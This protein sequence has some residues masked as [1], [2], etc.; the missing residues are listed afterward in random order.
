MMD[1]LEEHFKKLEKYITERLRK[2]HKP[3]HI[4]KTLLERGWLQEHIHK[5]LKE[6]KSSDEEKEE[7]GEKESPVVV[8]ETEFDKLY[9]IVQ[10]K[11]RV[12]LQEV[13]NLFKINKKLAEKWAEILR[14]A[15]LIDIYYPAVGDIELRKLKK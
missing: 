11:G 5:F 12:K 10:E 2:G 3:E 4:K 7:E 13:M 9:N 15:G 6:A 14:K 1:N 8:H